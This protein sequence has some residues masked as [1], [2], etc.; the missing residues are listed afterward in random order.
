MENRELFIGKE[1]GRRG[2]G[3]QGAVCT[4]APMLFLR[5]WLCASVYLCVGVKMGANGHEER[6]QGGQVN[7]R[8]EKTH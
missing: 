2:I 3:I 7:I 1:H 4:L 8:V 6:K 5:E